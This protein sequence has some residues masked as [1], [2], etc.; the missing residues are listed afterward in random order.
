MSELTLLPNEEILDDRGGDFGARR[1]TVSPGNCVITNQR[2]IVCTFKKPRD[3]I[4]GAIAGA[5]AKLVSPGAEIALHAI[6][7]A[8][9]IKSKKPLYPVFEQ[10]LTELLA[11]TNWRW[12]FA[13]GVYVQTAN[14][15]QFVI[16]LGT[17]KSRDNWLQVLVDTLAK[18]CPSVESNRDGDVLTLTQNRPAASELASRQ[19]LARFVINRGGKN[20]RPL[21]KSELLAKVRAGHV[22]ESDEILDTAKNESLNTVAL[23]KKCRRIEAT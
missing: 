2:L 21:S 9:A 10:P 20:T 4:K 19:D 12:G 11:I 18:H 14:V 7:L 17:R 15:D 8:Q 16:K 3:D 13:C 5:V 1:W 23:I 6:N 22:K